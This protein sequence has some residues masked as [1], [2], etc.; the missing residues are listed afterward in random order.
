MNELQYPLF[1]TYLD[2]WLVSGVRETSVITEAVALTGA[3]NARLNTAPKDRPGMEQFLAGRRNAPTAYPDILEPWPG[4]RVGSN[5]A[6]ETFT[7]YWPFDDIGLTYAWDCETPS[8]LAAWA[9]TELESDDAGELPF[10]LSACG[11]AVLWVNGSKV[12]E[13]T[14]YSHNT[15]ST[16]AVILPLAKGRNRILVY[17]DNY[18]ERDAAIILRLRYCGAGPEPVQ[19]LPVGTADAARLAEAE[20]L[21]RSLSFS[22]NHFTEGPVVLEYEGA[23]IDRPYTLSFRGGTEEN[24]KGGV[25][26][27]RTVE[28]LPHETA[29]SLGDCATFPLG[30]LLLSVRTEVE[31]LQITRPITVEIHPEAVLPRAL[32]TVAERKRQALELLARYGEQNTNRA[33]AILATCGDMAEAEH[34]LAIQ[35]DYIRQRYDCS[36]FYIVYYPYILRTYGSRGSGVLSQ[37]TEQ[38][39]T[40]CLLGFRY[41][42]D[43]PGNDAMWFWS[44]NHALMFHTCQLLA[45]ELFPD[46]TFTNSGM[47]GR[48]LQAKAKGLLY[49]WFAS[50]RRV[51]LAEW[52]SSPYLP[53]DTLG[54]GSLYAYAQ[55]PAMRELGRQGLD[56]AYYLLAIHSQKGIFACSSGRTYIKEQFGNWSNC[57]SGLSWI[58]Y[59]YGVPG[60]AGKGIVSLCLSDYEPPREF[61]QWFDIPAGQEM[62]CQTTQGADDYVDLY[63]YKTNGYLMTSADGF[64]PGTAGHQENVFQLT[65]DAVAQLWITHPGER[66]WNGAGRPSYWA[67]NGT[68]PLV[69]QYKGFAGILYDIDP[70]HPVD[71]THVYLPTMEFDRWELEENWAFVQKG[72]AYAAIYCSNGLRLQESGPNQRRECIAEGRRCIYLVRA[73]ENDEFAAFEDFCAAM[74][75]A[76]LQAD[77]V[78]LR[79]TFRDPIYGTLEGSWQETL[80]VNG[81]PMI[82]RGYDNYGRLTMQRKVDHGVSAGNAGT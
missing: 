42:I 51:G 8:L 18:A 44:E 73:A 4:G 5:D 25:Y 27:H 43:E 23:S 35:S 52:N 56:Y 39:L 7:V 21:M 46:E 76:P 71:F 31:G 57:P 80:R 77:P 14:P 72:T 22:R 67:G 62:I 13:Y 81:N 54:F 10:E 17:F 19:V 3:E 49:A 36:D 58:G 2:R 50:F 63:T 74:R 16:T 48:Q 47:T 55:D 59:G 1:H 6:Q 28:T 60:H 32:P 82:Y 41:W 33:L 79:Y 38:E 70:A 9:Y 65:F 12:M 11:S 20:A 29:V 15:P 61:A 69:N 34:L 37:E 30:F 45:G 24:T 66:V 75:N 40:D 64:C 78:G 68:L 53:I 26:W